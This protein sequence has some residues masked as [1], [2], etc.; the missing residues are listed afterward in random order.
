MHGNSTQA[1]RT[2]FFLLGL[3][4]VVVM[5][6]TFDMSYA[7]VWAGLSRAGYWFGACV[8]LWGVIYLM[9]ALGWRAVLGGD[10]PFGWIYKY[11][12]T[13]FALNNVTPVG[14]L[15]GEPY[16]IME[17]TPWVGAA[18]ASSSVLLCSMMHIFSHFCFWAMSIGLYLILYGRAV[19]WGM[20]LLLA[21]CTLFCAAGIAVFVFWFRRG[22][23]ARTLR[24]FARLP[25]IGRPVGAFAARH[26]DTI[27]LI[28][29]QIID[30]HRRRRGVFLFTFSMEFLARMLGCL[31]LQFI[32]FILTPDVSYLDC[33]LMQAFTS[34]LAN[35]L[36]VIPMQ[37]GTRE[38]GFA[39]VTS[40]LR[41]PP[42]FGVLTGLI[43]RV[44]ELV[45]IVVGLALMKISPRRE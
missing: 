10:V 20:G 16:R 12:V 40:G 23:S 6:L 44:R 2:L 8:A 18:R 38:G 1:F 32:L 24:A 7:E 31:E 27:A 19:G 45:W 25:V 35:L 15:G 4:A 33:V 21:L 36:F 14:L 11:T 3:A 43:T 5:L 13:G 37:M 26:A 41:L 29:A 34:L 30:L 22:L 39:I 17:L 28:D 9:N 42:A